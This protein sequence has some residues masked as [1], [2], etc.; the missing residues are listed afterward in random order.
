MPKLKK[1][2]KEQ[3]VAALRS[4]KY[5]QA[6]GVLAGPE[7]YCCLG[8]LCE[9]AIESGLPVSVS[10]EGDL[11]TYDQHTALMP[12]QVYEW[13]TL[14]KSTGC[15]DGDF[16]TPDGYLANMNDSGASFAQ[17]ADLIEEHL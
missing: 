9:V 15:S 7:G 11:T 14:K 17:I 1:R 3:W 4:G 5:Q 10:R 8:V 16:Y 2:V 12:P 13:A 6:R